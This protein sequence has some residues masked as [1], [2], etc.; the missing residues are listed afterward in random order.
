MCAITHSE[1]G[2]FQT[3][4]YTYAETV[5]FVCVA[6]ALLIGENTFAKFTINVSHI[7]VVHHIL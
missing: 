1:L 4:R 5:E 3:F 2:P 6:D 7:V